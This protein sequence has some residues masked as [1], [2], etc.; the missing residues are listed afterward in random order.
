MAAARP[1]SSRRKQKAMEGDL[2]Y[3]RILQEISKAEASL[4]TNQYKGLLQLVE[5]MNRPDSNITDRYELISQGLDIIFEGN[6]A[7]KA[8]WD[9]KLAPLAAIGNDQRIHRAKVETDPVQD[10]LEVTFETK[11]KKA[12]KRKKKPELPKKPSP[13]VP[14]TQE[15]DA[16]AV[17]PAEKALKKLNKPKPEPEPDPAL[18]QSK[19]T[20]TQDQQEPTKPPKTKARKTLKDRTDAR[21]DDLHYMVYL[22]ETEGDNLSQ[23]ISKLGKGSMGRVEG[24]IYQFASDRVTVNQ[25]ADAYSTEYGIPPADAARIVNDALGVMELEGQ[26]KRFTPKYSDRLIYDGKMVKTEDGKTVSVLQLQ[27]MDGPLKDRVEVAKAVRWT[28]KMVPMDA[29]DKNFD[30][31]YTQ[32]GAFN[33]F[34]GIPSDRVDGTFMPIINM[35]NSMRNSTMA[36]SSRMLNQIEDALGG[37]GAKRQ[38][39]INEVM[40]PKDKHGKP[41]ESPMRTVAQLVFQLGPKDDRPSNLIRQEWMSGDNGRIYS[42]N[43][44]A[45]SQ[46]GDLMKGILRTNEKHPVGGEPG[47]KMLMHSIGNLLGYDKL[48]PSYR[49]SAIFDHNL[50]ENLVKLANDPFGRQTLKNE[51]TGITPIGKMVKDGEGFFQ[52]LNAA[53]EVKDMVDWARERN[54][55]M[56]DLSDGDLLSHPDVVEDLGRNYTTDF[57]VQLDA[58]NNAYQNLGMM[59]GYD[60]VL[61]E[62]GML[63][64][65]PENDPDSGEVA[66]IYIKP[67]VGVAERIPELSELAL[68]QGKLRKLFK[69]PIGTY[70]YAAAFNSRKKSFRDT[71]EDMT[72]GAELFGMDGEDAMIDIDPALSAAMLSEE[73]HTFVDEHYDVNGDSKST[74]ATRKRVVANGD[75]FQVQNAEGANGAWSAGGMK[76]KTPQDAV[77]ETYSTNLFARMSRELVREMNT[78]YPDVQKYLNYAE[79]VS[80]VVKERGGA[81]IVVPTADGID[82]RYSFKNTPGFDAAPVTLADGRVV[83]LGVRN[84]SEKLAGRG[85]AA[86]MAH[87][88]D[89]FA[90]LSWARVLWAVSKV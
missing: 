13:E 9:R 61:R 76:F 67:A 58:K 86:F 14:I 73:G 88:M 72:D 7:M 41:D 90:S 79:I 53:H 3:K 26:L 12:K 57:V 87:Q 2:R 82:L 28:E 50:V 66:D 47:M 56:D 71:L 52:V 29:P 18:D 30:P 45:H 23:H 39:T 11:V 31:N 19:T 77:K 16:P 48:A 69:G 22:A 8:F 40:T 46:A 78:L 15:P 59:M 85:L 54:P 5:E 70:L 89:A 4:P 49:R 80:K 10:Q 44:L 62:T 42:K 32:D 38:G 84:A 25:L 60:K 33:A 24:L 35:L 1:T 63:P 20:E 68:P 34:K 75:K 37:T 17:T 27:F 81:D 74:K 21:V 55:N 65:S 83:D 36:V 6:P 64:M 43:S 51:R